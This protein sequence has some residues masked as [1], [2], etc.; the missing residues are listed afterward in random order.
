MAARK[1]DTV[2][3][4]VLALKDQGCSLRE[5]ATRLRGKVSKSTVGDILGEASPASVN[6]E[7]LPAPPRGADPGT[8]PE[9]AALEDELVH[10]H[11]RVVGARAGNLRNYLAAAR[12]YCELVERVQKLRPPPPVEEKSREDLLR[13]RD[14]LLK[15]I[16]GLIQAKEAAAGE[17]AG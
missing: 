13:E 14:E 5:I 17:S 6:P 3:K 16:D 8:D 1:S 15:Q 10:L 7:G 4:Q 2:R 12:G 11:G 9:L